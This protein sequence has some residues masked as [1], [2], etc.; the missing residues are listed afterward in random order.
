MDTLPPELHSLICHFASLPSS[1]SSPW[2]PLSPNGHDLKDLPGTTIRALNSVSRYFYHISQP[3]L[4]TTVCI[5]SGLEQAARLLEKLESDASSASSSA[6]DGQ[7]RREIIIRH[8]FISD[9]ALLPSS[10]STPDSSSSSSTKIIPRLLTLTSP[11]LYSLALIF[12][13]SSSTNPNLSSTSLI[14]RVYRTYFPCLEYLTISGYYP[15]PSRPFRSRSPSPLS[16]QTSTC[17]PPPLPPTNFPSLTTL[18][19]NGNPNPTGILQTGCLS[20]SFPS[21]AYLTLSGINLAK[22][23]FV[24]EVECA[25]EGALSSA[26]TTTSRNNGNEED[27]K[28]ETSAYDDDLFPARFPP[29]LRRHPLQMEQTAQE[30]L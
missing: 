12:S 9:T 13:P 30:A 21:L 3:Y 11:T 4:Y 16:G 26:G 2:P 29:K 14:G 23:G 15:F 1:S 25:L 20:D 6:I 7:R 22:K 27:G 19:L 8:L 24:K 17:F 18:H 5:T 10:S 28:N